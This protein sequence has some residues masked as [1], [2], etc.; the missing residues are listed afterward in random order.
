M[1]LMPG[2][3]PLFAE[4]RH[5]RLKLW[6][7]RDR[8]H[9]RLKALV[10]RRDDLV[11]IRVAEKNRASAPDRDKI[12]ARSCR[13]LI[14]W[15]NREIMKIEQAIE[16]LIA[17]SESLTRKRNIL[18]DMPGIGNTSASAILA[19]MPELGMCT[20][21]RIASLAGVA[22]HPRDSG[23]TN[24][25]RHTTGGRALAKKA[26]FMPAMS[27]VRH[28]DKLANSY[29]SLIKNGKQKLVALTAVMRKMI[30]IANA[31][32]RDDANQQLS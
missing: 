32:I 20:R 15:L 25:Y 1:P 5:K 8:V 17:G 2:P 11:A 27:A 12:I 10:L 18:T 7:V 21:R 31:R 28:D 16:A 22:P 30:V 3:S 26:L 24:R 19:H 13:N 23:R 6:T 29:N 14:A 4:E 9:A